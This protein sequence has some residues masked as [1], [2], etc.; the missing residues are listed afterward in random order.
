MLVSVPEASPLSVSLEATPEEISLGDHV[1]VRLSVEH[2][3]RDV[4]SLPAFDP[5]PLAAPPAAATPPIP[6]QASR[7]AAGS[8][9]PTIT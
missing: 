8:Q 5:A 2:D 7:N 3:A 4:Y 9:F 6:I 1:Q